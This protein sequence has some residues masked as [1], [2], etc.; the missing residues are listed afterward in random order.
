MAIVTLTTDF[1]Y[2]E[3]YVGVM[4]GVMLGINRA[5]TFVDLTHG[6]EARNIRQ[7]AFA[8]AYAAPWFP[9]GAIHLAVVDPGVGTQRKALVLEADGQYFVGPDNGIF[10][11]VMARAGTWRA[12]EIAHSELSL[13]EISGT[14]HGR[15]VFA[16]AAAW[17]SRGGVPLEAF[18]PPVAAPER[19]A[20][21]HAM[22]SAGNLIEGEVVHTDHF[23]NAITN[24][25]RE[26]VEQMARELEPDDGLEIIVG[27]MTAPGLVKT[28]SD[29]PDSTSLWATFSSGGA[30]E[31]F[32]RGGS[33]ARLFGLKAGDH[34]E[35]RF[36]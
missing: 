33:A 34:V 30:I 23:G 5:I 9:E 4:K 22:R 20:Q 6:V 13:P 10:T 32:V 31:L 11:L 17:I 28:Y 29:A 26:L 24:I 3:P 21:T 19:L 36:F 14:F 8:L 35:V 27:S 1:G 7:A 16:P 2:A 25:S 12:H 18:G 15:D